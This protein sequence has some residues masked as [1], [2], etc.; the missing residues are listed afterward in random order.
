MSLKR[1]V[2]PSYFFKVILNCTIEYNLEEMVYLTLFYSL[3]LPLKTL[4]FTHLLSLSL[5][6]LPVLS[7]RVALHTKCLL[8]PARK[9]HLFFGVILGL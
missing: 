4:F 7:L 8:I 2:E 3:H 1:R 9:T 5:A 6:P